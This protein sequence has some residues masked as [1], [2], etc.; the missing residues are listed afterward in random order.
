MPAL[1]RYVFG[2]LFA[3]MENVYREIIKWELS[4]ADHKN[5]Y[6]TEPV[7]DTVEV[8]GELWEK[9]GK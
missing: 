3:T 6:P 8:S 1:G 5:A 4:W 9:Y 2:I 7:G